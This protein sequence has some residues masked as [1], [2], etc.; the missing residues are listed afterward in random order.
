MGTENDP[1]GIDTDRTDIS[2]APSPDADDNL[3]TEDNKSDPP[4]IAP[5]DGDDDG[6]HSSDIEAER[7]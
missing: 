1:D 2:S 6:R 7:D 3:G 4:R 5:S